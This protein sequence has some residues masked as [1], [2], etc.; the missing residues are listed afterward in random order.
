MP[1]RDDI[2]F[3]VVLFGSGAEC[4]MPPLGQWAAFRFVKLFDQLLD[5]VP[6]FGA[7]DLVSRRGIVQLVFD[8][9]PSLI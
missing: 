8:I 6:G 4:A 5:N 1:E 9:M 3:R 7:G 2:P